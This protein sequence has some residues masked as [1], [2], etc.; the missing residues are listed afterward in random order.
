MRLELSGP[1]RITVRGNIK[2]TQ[3]YLDIRQMVSDVV[4]RGR[5]AV[6][7]DL[8]ESLSMPSAVIGFF[9]KLVNRDKIKVSMTVH[10]PRLLELLD[11]LCLRELFGAQAPAVP[12]PASR[13]D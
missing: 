3:D 10:D 5:E 13:L 12:G 11:E 4:A 8:L 2:T 9:V 7:L 6:H 1:D